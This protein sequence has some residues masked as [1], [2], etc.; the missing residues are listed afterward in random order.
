M[1]LVGAG[2]TE[3]VLKKGFCQ[4]IVSKFTAKVTR[5][6]REPVLKS[7]TEPFLK[8]TKSTKFLYECTLKFSIV[9]YLED[10]LSAYNGT[11]QILCHVGKLWYN[12]MFWDNQFASLLDEIYSFSSHTT[13]LH[14]SQL[15]VT[16]KAK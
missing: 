3:Y 12:T 5:K 9:S 8:R 13:Y 10:C 6:K 14:W 15:Q 16:L 4:I 11:K 7:Q 2:L 1:L